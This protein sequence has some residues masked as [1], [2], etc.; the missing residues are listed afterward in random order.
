MDPADYEAWYHTPRGA[1]IARREMALMTRLLRPRP[2]ETLLDVGAGTGHFTRRFT[3]AGVDATGLEPDPGMLAYARSRHPDLAFI[4]GEAGELPFAE[5]SFDWVV[6][7]T[8]LCFVAEPEAALAAMWRVARRGVL[9]GLLNRRSLLHRRKAGRGSYAG[10]RWDTPTDAA[11]WARRL[12][13]APVRMRWGTAVFFPGGGRAAR[14]AEPLL[15]RKLPW[16]AFL[17]VQW[18]KPGDPSGSRSSRSPAA[19][20]R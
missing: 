1:W 16:G 11:D 9:V 8:S 2:G 17:A 6:A 4:Q 5:G 12:D 3:D 19:G 20:N 14:L 15:P 13:P 10:A 18:A 7:V